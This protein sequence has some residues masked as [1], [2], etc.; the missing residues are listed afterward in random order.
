MIYKNGF[1]YNSEGKRLYPN[2]KQLEEFKA[3]QDTVE[4]VDVQTPTAVVE[5]ATEGLTDAVEVIKKPPIK[6]TYTKKPK[7]E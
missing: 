7:A 3:L 6:R 4:A 1:W 5:D 2:R